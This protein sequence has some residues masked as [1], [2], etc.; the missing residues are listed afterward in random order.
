[1]HASRHVCSF[2]RRTVSTTHALP[3]GWMAANLDNAVRATCTDGACLAELMA[4]VK[5]VFA[6]DEDDER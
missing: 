6:R 3:R 2:C 5:R 1:M 4:E